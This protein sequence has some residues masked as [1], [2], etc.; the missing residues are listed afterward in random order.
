MIRIIHKSLP[1]LKPG[2]MIIIEDIL[3]ALDESWFYNDLKTILDE[4][5]TVFFVDLEHD[6][7]NSGTLENDKVLILIKKGDRIFNYSLL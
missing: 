6:S 1:F 7:R 3:K 2:G 5:Q 4:F